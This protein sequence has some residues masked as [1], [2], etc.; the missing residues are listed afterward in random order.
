MKCPRCLRINEEHARQC[1]CGFPFFVEDE[2]GLQ[3]WFD[4]IRHIL[5]RA[6][7]T[8][9]TPWQQSGKGGSFEDW[10]RLRIPISEC[11]TR[12]GTF[13]DIG[14]A[15][16]FLLECLLN[17]T[18]MK[19]IDLVP[20][21]LDYAPKLVEM[22]RERLLAFKDH[23]FTGNAWDWQPPRRF[24]YVR[25]EA[26]YVPHNLRTAYLKRLLSEFLEDGGLLL[27]THYRSSGEDLTRD[28]LD[29]DLR[30]EG[31][32]VIGSVSGFDGAGREKC[33]V[34]MLQP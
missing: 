25:T 27:A 31:F 13:L 28:W 22:A 30:T 14:C 33:R 19:N 18:K 10:V 11:V 5:Q 8:A 23:I 17:W 9:P 29:E 15:N 4:E 16:G 12:S 7:V 34:A 26:V 20:Y 24:T 21:G 1:V 2:R 32:N 6:Y 3:T